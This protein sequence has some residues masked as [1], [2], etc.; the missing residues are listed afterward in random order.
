MALFALVTLAAEGMMGVSL[1]LIPDTARQSVVFSM[2]ALLALVIIGVVI[3]GLKQPD[4]LWSKPRPP[5]EVK[6]PDPLPPEKK[7]NLIE[8]N[9][10]AVV[11]ADAPPLSRDNW[12]TDLQQ[13]RR[14][15]SQGL[16]YSGPSYYLNTQLCVID[17]NP[18][19]ELIFKPILKRIRCRHV[20]YFIAELANFDQVFMHARDFSDRQQRG[21]LPLV[22]LEPLVYNSETYGVVEFEKVACQLTDA[23]ADLKAWGVALMLKQ[24]DWEKFNPDLEKRL[25]E[26]KRWSLY[27]VSYDIILG[28]FPPY[29]ALIDEV[30]N[31]IPPEARQVMDLG[32]GTGNVSAALL[33]RGYRV[34]AI[35]N[36]Q[37]MVEKMSN[38]KLDRNPN[39]T[40]HKES[41]EDLVDFR[42]ESFDAV[43]AVN[44]LYAL[45]DPLKC[46]RDVARILRP[47]GIFA[48]STT[49]SL[50][51]LDQLL[52]AIKTYLEGSGKMQG[53]EEHFQRVFEVNKDIE[54]TI[55]QCHSRQDYESWLVDSGFEIIYNKPDSYENA[56]MVIHARKL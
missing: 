20:N 19:F 26:H 39:L 34:T 46:I 2:V 48:F 56:V 50:T 13:L 10:D 30:I 42:N 45:D 37:S 24:I 51:A 23:N 15:M 25:R 14:V 21:E 38:K 36:N 54:V 47:G 32:A 5:M 31:G 53:N 3:I 7:Q 9:K 8:E 1:R 43:T 16:Q 28:S 33:K 12:A 4:L 11:G 18:A 40:I 22:D 44:V 17:W 41:V 49:H 35:E 29:V 27:A 6:K 55:A 52:L